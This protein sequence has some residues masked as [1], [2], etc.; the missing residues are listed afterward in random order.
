MTELKAEASSRRSV[1]YELDTALGH[2]TP[3][4]RA[5]RGAEARAA[6]P[7][8]AHAMFDPAS[9]RPD[10]IALLEEQAASRVPEL[11][12]VRWGRMMV[13]PFTYYRGA[14]L[15]MASDLATTPVTG[16][17]VQAC[18]DAHLSNFGVFGSAERKLV[19]DVNDFD[20]TLPGPWEWDVKRLA[21][22]LEIAARSNG[23]TGKQ[24]RKIVTDSVASYRQA[25]R[26]F[27]GMTNLEVWYTH[28]DVDQL[29]DRFGAKLNARQRKAVDKGV[30]KA[31]TRDSMQELSKLTVLVDG[32]PRIISDPPLLV[33]VDELL[34]DRMERSA[35]ESQV[36]ELIGKY[37]RT[38]ETNRRYLL[39]QYVF[40]DLAR[41]VVGVGSVGTRCWIA[42]MLGRDH[43][44][45]LFL[46]IKEAGESVLSRF[47]GASKFANQGQRVVAGQ[48]LMQ[49][50][51]DIFLGWQ[52]VPGIDGQQRD[53]YVRQLRDWKFSIDTET[54][55]PRGMRLYG[56]ACGWTLAR[57][58]ARSG[59]R[60][61]IAAYLGGSAV[62]DEAITQFARA[63]ADQNERDHQALVD[64]VTSGRI[65]AERGL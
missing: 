49:A 2:L 58:H 62:F 64:A 34:P 39:D 50:T 5:A 55:V 13:S 19:F 23:F 33:P 52:R 30:I 41:K 27:A 46:Q 38:L 48:L 17:A 26:A 3:T 63:Y 28:M 21:A 40:A 12:P 24:R 9:G 4:E 56:E 25:M 11:V 22:S 59:D 65:I 35:F 10:P 7:R 53:F 60:I 42:L 6:V 47:L 43:G 37:R 54:M 32:Q 15:P 51:S 36:N 31:R 45:P 20:E 14:A 61:A 16:L 1:R 18:G 57:A 8:E 29:K 44:D